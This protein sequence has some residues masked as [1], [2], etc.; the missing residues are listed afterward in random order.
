M[1]QWDKSSDIILCFLTNMHVHCAPSILKRG[2]FY[3]PGRQWRNALFTE[4][5]YRELNAYKRVGPCWQ[6]RVLRDDIRKQTSTHIL[7]RSGNRYLFDNNH[8]VYLTTQGISPCCSLSNVSLWISDRYKN[9]RCDNSST[10]QWR[11]NARDG[12]SNHQQF[13]CLLNRLFRRRSKKTPKIH[14]TGLC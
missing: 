3:H 9:M 1:K 12:V 4:A 2:C 8:V 7:L 13:D 5:I 14:V 11:H 10:L 6:S